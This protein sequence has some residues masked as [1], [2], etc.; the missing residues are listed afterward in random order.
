MQ[1]DPTIHVIDDDAAVRESLGFLLDAA[2]FSPVLYDSAPAFLDALQS[3]IHGCVLTDVRMPE[4][5]G[6]DLLKRLRTQDT[7]IPV[8]VMTGHGDVPL[9]VEAMKQGAADFIEKPFD[10]ERLLLAL[11]TALAGGEADEARAR[12]HAEVRQRVV[13]LSAREQEVLD[14]LV[15]GKPNKIIAYELGISP[16]TVEVYRANVMHKMKA[17]SLSE[18]VRM[19]LLNPA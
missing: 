7:H 15:A 11:K 4:M 14:G 18:L 12:E 9:A 3:E 2:G 13:S 10:D 19:V 8:V 17:G 5:S 6:L 16:R 1:P